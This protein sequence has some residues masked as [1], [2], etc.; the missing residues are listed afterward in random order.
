MTPKLLDLNA[1]HTP[2]QPGVYQMFNKNGKII[3]VGKAKNLKKRLTSYFRKNLLSQKT[4]VLMS[5]VV[6]IKVIITENEN[7]ALLLEANLIK[8]YKPRY[9][10]LLRD[11]K[12]YPYLYLSTEKKFPRLDLHRGARKAKGRYFGPYPSARSV[13]ENLALIQKLFNLRQCKDSFFANRSRPCLQ[14]QIKRCTA[15]CVSYVSEKEYQCQV[16]HAVLFLEGKN[17]TIIDELQQQMDQASTDR[18]YEKAALC[19]DK[20]AQ[21]R[22]IQTQQTVTGDAGNIDVISVVGQQQHY[23]VAILYIRSGRM[24]GNKVFFPK[25]PGNSLPSEVLTSFLTQ[26]YLNPLH[27]QD[28]LNKI[29]VSQKIIDK[30][31]LTGVLQQS[32]GKRFRIIDRSGELYK[33]WCH[34]AESNAQHALTQRV[35]DKKTVAHKL[36]ALQ[37]L[38]GMEDSI[39]RIECF[40]V[41]HTQGDATVASCVVYGENGALNKEYRRYSIKDVA[42]GDDYAAMQQ[43]LMR[44]YLK[45][46]KQD[47]VLPDVIIIDGGK[48]QLHQ[49]ENVMEEL[50]LTDITLMSVA[51]GV[52]RKPG[53]EKIW[54]QAKVHPLQI[55]A[56]SLV[57]HLIQF[58]RDESHRFAITSHRKKR[59][60][61]VLASPLEGIAGVGAKRR[62]A[63]LRYFGG[64]QELLKAGVSEIAKVP[65][66]SRALAQ[67]IYDSLHE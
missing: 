32:F 31:W 57:L 51:K 34:M 9:N 26:Y 45:L 64:Q 65:G 55:P 60:K 52:A 35:A 48:G 66:I 11:D 10:V 12:S 23:A 20:I 47:A 4:Q 61:N 16:E 6:D 53:L 50:Q 33:N 38:L 19:R 41:S 67:Q 49:A 25:V 13:R 18:R 5:Q 3:Y 28:R 30:S 54:L 17:N 39:K 1:I 2:H 36:Q 15:P 59:A 27:Q 24:L 29:I 56:D 43:V 21:L 63:L 37:L 62:S 22:Y 40:D 7:E 14:Y 58:I 44:R 8:Q 46:K 42:A